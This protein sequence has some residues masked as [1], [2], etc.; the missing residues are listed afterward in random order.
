MKQ[1]NDFLEPLCPGIIFFS[2]DGK[3]INHKV[4][5]TQRFKGTNNKVFTWFL[6]VQVV[7]VVTLSK[8]GSCCEEDHGD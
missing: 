4:T 7:K 2:L 3:R 8:E 1:L 6:R 5:K